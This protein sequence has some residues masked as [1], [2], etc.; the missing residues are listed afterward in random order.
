LPHSRTNTDKMTI[1]VRTG[2]QWDESTTREHI[3]K[4]TFIRGGKFDL[5]IIRALAFH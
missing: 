4:V 2:G 3:V 1:F 5:F